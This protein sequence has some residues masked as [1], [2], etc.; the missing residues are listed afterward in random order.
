[1]VSIPVHTTIN[2]KIP[3]GVLSP[4]EISNDHDSITCKRCKRCKYFW[5]I[6][7]ENRKLST[8]ELSKI[9]NSNVYT[10]KSLRTRW[11]LQR[12]YEE[13][14]KNEIWKIFKYNDL[15]IEVSNF[16]R[17]RNTKNKKLYK[18]TL[19]S[20]TYKRLYLYTRIKNKRVSLE[21]SSIVY[22]CF[23]NPNLRQKLYFKDENY[24]NLQLSNLTTKL[25]LQI[26]IEDWIDKY[27]ENDMRTK[28]NFSKISNISHGKIKYYALKMRQELKIPGKTEIPL[29]ELCLRF[30]GRFSPPT[31]L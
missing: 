7:S 9:L 20:T 11:N 12:E 1:M 16:G 24:K 21:A 26:L 4:K 5:K 14:L 2:G 22:R 27:T 29:Y 30:I 8:L 10:I 6:L 13:N 31:F 15:E 23:E 17:F 19:R 28:L 25:P 18:P 3:C